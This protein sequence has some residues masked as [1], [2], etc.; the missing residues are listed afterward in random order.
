MEFTITILGIDTPDPIITGTLPDSELNMPYSQELTAS[1]A[2]SP[3]TWSYSGTLPSG[4]SF[5]ETTG[6][7][8]TLSGSP[9]TAGTY[10]FSVTVTDT[11][12]KTAEKS[13]T[14]NIGN[15]DEPDYPDDPEPVPGP[16]YP[17][18]TDYTDTDYTDIYTDYTDTDTDKADDS[19]S[20]TVAEPGTSNG[21]T[22][23][24][25]NESSSSSE[26]SPHDNSASGGCNSAFTL[27]GLLLPLTALRKSRS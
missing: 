27:L 3:Y 14:V 5:R 19:K 4:L 25:N 7:H 9:T 15:T 6:N 12:G 11:Y 1:N 17:D 10:N 18:Y 26:I 21:T 20:G 23:I 8:Y 13:F 24:V 16:V 22:V 2:T